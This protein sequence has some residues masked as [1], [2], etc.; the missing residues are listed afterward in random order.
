MPQTEVLQ[1]HK[2]WETFGHQRKILIVEDELLVSW[3]LS[4]ALGKLGFDVSVADSGEKALDALGSR[5]YDLVIT[6]MNLPMIDGFQVAAMA[7]SSG[8][9]IPVI[10]VSA[11]DVNSRTGREGSGFIDCFIEKPFEFEQIRTVVKNLLDNGV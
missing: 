9:I 2:K 6:D 5:N 8:K 7:K 1:D 4:Q 11:M 3:S 10:M